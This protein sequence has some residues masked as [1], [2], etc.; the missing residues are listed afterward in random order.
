MKVQLNKNVKV[1]VANTNPVQYNDVYTVIESGNTFI[2]VPPQKLIYFTVTSTIRNTGEN[3]MFTFEFYI[4]GQVIDFINLKYQDIPAYSN[5]GKIHIE[6]P[7]LDPLTQDV[8]F[9]DKLGYTKDGDYVGCWFNLVADFITP[10]TNK[11]L[12]CRLI[13]SFSTN[14]PAVVEIINFAQIPSAGKKV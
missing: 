6:F 7:R 12:K 10:E 13:Q 11:Y 9:E 3:N 14:I 8:W 5:G 2:F 1:P 4:K